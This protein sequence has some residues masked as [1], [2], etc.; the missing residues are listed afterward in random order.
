MASGNALQGVRETV[1]TLRAACVLAGFIVS[2]CGIVGPSCTD[3][4]G[5]LVS[6]SG[7]APGGGVVRHTV[8]SPKNSNLRLRLSWTQPETTLGFRA[9][10]TSCG[11]HTGCAMITVTP[12]M[13]QREMVV[14]GWEG[15]TW[16]IE[17]ANP[18]EQEVPFT[19]QVNYEIACER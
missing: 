16:S 13:G 18:S 5:S 4:S 1:R 2:G 15:K 11:G 3:E 10:I 14:D 7:L 12:P 6:I 17:I 9:T 19:L 8:V